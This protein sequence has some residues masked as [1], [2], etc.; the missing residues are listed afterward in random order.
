MSV[1]TATAHVQSQRAQSDSHKGGTSQRP[2]RPTFSQEL[3]RLAQTLSD[4]PTRISEIL[5]A[6][7]GRGFD[8]LLV[9][10]SL[11]FVTPIPLPGLSIPFGL[12]VAL[13]GARLAVGQKPWLPRRLLSKQLPPRFLSKLLK[14]ASWILRMFEVGLRPRLAFVHESLVFRR[15][16]GTLVM[17]SG[18]FLILPVPLPFSNS[19]PA[20]TVLLVAAGA[21]ERDGAAFLG[22]CFM[23][24]VTTAYFG[25]LAFGGAH[26]IDGLKHAI[27]GTG[28]L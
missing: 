2:Y 7:Q 24:V 11:P 28:L 10:I 4:R 1:R 14:A 5:Q 22:G 16:A 27:L 8:L 6:T 9:C 12:L 20:W 18:L 21:L 26:A 17:L 13:I 23:F 25:L 19:L 3:G 15:V